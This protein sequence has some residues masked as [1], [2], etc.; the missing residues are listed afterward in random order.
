MSFALA[1]ETGRWWAPFDKLRMT[2]GQPGGVAIVHVDLR[3]N[4]VHEAEAVAWLSAGEQARRDRFLQVAAAR[5]YTLCRA[6]LRAILCGRLGCDNRELAIVSGEFGKPFALARGAAAEI[7][8]NV[9]HS[10][11]HGLIALAR[12]GRLGVDVEELGA[13]SELVERRLDILIDSVLTPGERADVLSMTPTGRTRGFLRL[14]TTK[15]ALLKALGAGLSLDMS[16]LE[17]PARMLRGASCGVFRFPDSAETAWRVADIG[18]HD[19]AAA[20][21]CEIVPSHDAI[22]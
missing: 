18:C 15:E 21:A 13:P 20:V 10:G 17:V 7:S 6:A 8:F 16:T 5:R 1:G 9:S 14:W 11:S 22:T 2:G 12:R 3:P 19:F 4:A